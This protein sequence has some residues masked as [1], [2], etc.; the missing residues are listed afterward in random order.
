MPPPRNRRCNDVTFSASSAAV[1]RPR[2]WPLSHPPSDSRWALPSTRKRAPAHGA[3]P[4]PSSRWCS[5]L[6][7]RD[8]APHRH[9]GRA[10]RRSAGIHRPHAG[11]WD[12]AEER[13]RFL[14][15]L[16]ADRH[17]TRWRGAARRGA[18]RAGFRHRLAGPASAEEA[19]VRLKSMTVYGY[20][21]SKLV[22]EDVLHTVIVP[23]PLR[24]AAC[25]R[26]DDDDAPGSLGRDRG[27]IRDHRRMGGQG[28]LRSGAPGAGARGGPRHRAGP[29]LRRARAGLADAV[30]RLGRPARAGA[31]S[32]GAAALLR[33]RRVVVEVLRQRPRESVRD[34]RGTG[35][36][37]IRGRQVGGR[38]LTWGR[39][40]YRW[41]DLDFEANARDGVAVDWPIRYRDIAPWYDHVERFI[42]VSGQAEGLGQLPDGQFL[43]PMEMNCAERDVAASMQRAM[44]PRPGDDDRALRDS[45]PG[46]QR[47]RRLSLLRALRAGLH[48]PLVFHAARAAP[49]PRRGRPAGSPSGRNSVVR[50]ASSRDGRQG[51]R[52]AGH[53]RGGRCKRSNSGP[54]SS[55]SAPPPSSRPGSSQSAAASAVSASRAGSWATISWI[56]FSWRARAGPSPATSGSARPATGPTGSTSR[57][58]GT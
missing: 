46:A 13:D 4:R 29:R 18:H 24:R 39:Q 23:G 54:G 25:R 41:S 21:T 8:P 31:R 38:S 35:F 56:T 27:R 47:P 49:C 28:A 22:Q 20:F 10:R 33:L 2:C 48:H 34:R 37:W 42:G 12:T 11:R 15:G 19:W 55:S 50:T 40:V 7:E 32:A 51:D 9:S 3:R 44:G 45:H 43:P 36:D 5:D 14:R 53:R 58:S 26:A 16:G 30:P 1:P 57:A 52:R 17:A 6:A